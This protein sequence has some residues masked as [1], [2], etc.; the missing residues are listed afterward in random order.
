[1]TTA[2]APQHV[3][4]FLLCQRFSGSRLTCFPVAQ[5]NRIMLA[6]PRR[7]DNALGDNLADQ[8]GLSGVL[9]ALAHRVES[10]A[11]D[12]GRFVVEIGFIHYERQNRRHVVA[13]VSVA[14]TSARSRALLPC[15]FEKSRR[16]PP[17]R[18][19]AKLLSRGNLNS[20]K[21]CHLG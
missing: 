9:K 10:L 16:N 14:R 5:T 13:F 15:G 3:G 19:D 6:L 1:M 11:H 18:K 21:Q 7:F 12:A 17:I 20:A 2:S 4:A 8:G